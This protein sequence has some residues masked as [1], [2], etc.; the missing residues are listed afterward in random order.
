V[1]H[2]V[3][4]HSVLAALLFFVVLSTCLCVIGIKAAYGSH[5]P[6]W[7]ILLF[8]S[9]LAISVPIAG[10]VSYVFY[11]PRDRDSDTSTRTP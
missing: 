7:A 4:A 1:T 11:V 6:L 9:T 8:L 10:V 5:A 3:K 2:R